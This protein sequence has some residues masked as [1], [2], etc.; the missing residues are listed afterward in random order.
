VL[1]PERAHAGTWKVF[2]QRLSRLR[3]ARVQ[4]HIV[5]KGHGTVPQRK[6]GIPSLLTQVL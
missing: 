6:L 4:D 3:N 1:V 2:K 5:V